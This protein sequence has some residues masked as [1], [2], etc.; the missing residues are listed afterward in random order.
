M[1]GLSYV[2]LAWLPN[3]PPRAAV[4]TSTPSGRLPT[5]IGKAHLDELRR[6]VRELI[7]ELHR[8]EL[9]CESPKQV[10]STV[11]TA[12]VALLSIRCGPTRQPLQATRQW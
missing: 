7:E 2:G 3:Q 11:E 1:L 6:D 9:L 4:L 10:P 8:S 5:G 12:S